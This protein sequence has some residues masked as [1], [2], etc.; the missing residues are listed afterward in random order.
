MIHGTRRRKSNPT[1]RAAN[2][3]TAPDGQAL[4]EICSRRFGR[5]PPG[6]LGKQETTSGREATLSADVILGG[7]KS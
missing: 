7:V 5:S 6:Y 4:F 2:A 1:C 3:A